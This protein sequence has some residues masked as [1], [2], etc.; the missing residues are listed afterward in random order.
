MFVEAKVMTAPSAEQPEHIRVNMLNPYSLCAQASHFL[1]FD[2]NTGTSDSR[3]IPKRKKAFYFYSIFL[4]A[5]VIMCPLVNYWFAY[6][7]K[8]TLSLCF[9]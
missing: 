7:P 4:L 9:Y 8:L 6:L 5:C 1:A 2:T 3:G